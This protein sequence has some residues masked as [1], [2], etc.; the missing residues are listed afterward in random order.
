ML[1]ENADD[2]NQ[3]PE[4]DRD[5]LDR[6]LVGAEGDDGNDCCV[7]GMRQF[8]GPGTL[9]RVG[10]GSAASD[11]SGR[12]VRATRLA[13]VSLSMCRRPAGLAIS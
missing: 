9:G 13:L 3:D 12:L 7:R 6:T 8:V 11:T 5:G 10:S 2:Q 4:Q 1:A